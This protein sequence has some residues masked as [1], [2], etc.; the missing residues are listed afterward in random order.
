MNL[1]DA[2]QAH[3]DTALDVDLLLSTP[4]SIVVRA[5]LEFEDGGSPQEA[6]L[7]VARHHCRGDCPSAAALREAAAACLARWTAR[8]SK[9]VPARRPL[10]LDAVIGGRWQTLWGADP[11]P[12]AA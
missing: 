2:S 4:L 12:Q 6:G 1:F 8:R 11:V 3:A 9:R 5:R 10:R 7:V